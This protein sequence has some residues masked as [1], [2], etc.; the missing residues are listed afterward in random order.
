MILTT[1]TSLSCALISICIWIALFGRRRPGKLPPGPK[2]YPLVGNALQ[3]RDRPWHTFVKWKKQYGDIVYFRLFNQDA[4]VLNSAKVA[5]DLLDRRGSNYSERLRMP[6]VEHSN[7]GLNMVFM[8][9]GA[10]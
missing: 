10:T 3:L 7:G 8:N 2:G 9:P 4:I 5:S 1:T 6:V